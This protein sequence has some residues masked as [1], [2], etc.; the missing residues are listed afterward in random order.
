V[1]EEKVFVGDVEGHVEGEGFDQG[2]EKVLLVV[3]WPES[4]RDCR[5]Y[6]CC[7]HIGRVVAEDFDG[8]GD[9]G[10]EK[11][12]EFLDVFVVGEHAYALS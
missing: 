7:C 2:S 4:G 9:D 8:R 12:V 10:V 11:V 6:G 5:R 3:A 1:V